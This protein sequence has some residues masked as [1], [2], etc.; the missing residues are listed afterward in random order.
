MY[1]RVS[2]A[3]RVGALG[4]PCPS[5]LEAMT[6]RGLGRLPPRAFRSFS[7][8]I[9]KFENSLL[10]DR[11][12]EVQLLMQSGEPASAK[13]A[14]LREIIANRTS[15]SAEALRLFS[16]CDQKYRLHT[17]SLAPALTMALQTH[18]DVP[19]APDV[20]YAMSCMYNWNDVHLDLLK[21]FAEKFAA[22]KRKHAWSAPIGHA[23]YGL[24][25]MQR[26]EPEVLLLLRQMA[27]VISAT[28]GTFETKML[29]KALFG[30]KG[31][32]DNSEE[33]RLLLRAF[34]P[35]LESCRDIMDERDISLAFTGLR[36]M[37]GK[38][39]ETREIIKILSESM[40]N[41]E[42]TMSAK[43]LGSILLSL[44]RQSGEYVETQMLL[45]VLA[46]KV[47][48][49]EDTFTENDLSNALNGMQ[50]MSSDDSKV[51][52]F[53]TVMKKKVF[54]C[55]QTFTA[56]NAGRA[57][58]G[59][60]N[61]KH[62][63]DMEL[64]ILEN[65]DQVMS[66][67]D[68]SL[69]VYGC[70]RRLWLE[71]HEITLLR[72]LRKK[73]EGCQDLLNGQSVALILYG[74]QQLTGEHEEHRLML[75]ALC[76]KRWSTQFHPGDIAMCSYGLVRMSSRHTEVQQILRRLNE[77]LTECRVQL[78]PN[79]IGG[80]LSGLQNFNAETRAVREMLRNIA[81]RIRTC[82]GVFTAK[83][84]GQCFRGLSHMTNDHKEVQLVLDALID[85]IEQDKQFVS[86][87]YT[88]TETLL[89][90]PEYTAPPN[91]SR[92]VSKLCKDLKRCHGS[93]ALSQHDCY[94]LGQALR[95]CTGLEKPLFRSLPEGVQEQ[96]L[97]SLRLCEEHLA[98]VDMESWATIKR[99]EDLCAN[100]VK[101]SVERFESDVWDIEMT[102]NVFLH[103][104]EAD[105]LLTLSRKKPAKTSRG[106]MKEKSKDVS[107][108]V[109]INIEI[110]GLIH[111]RDMKQRFHAM[112]DEYLSKLHGVVIL[113][114][115]TDIVTLIPQPDL[116]KEEANKLVNMI[117]GAITD[118][119]DQKR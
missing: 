73:L 115:Q 5:Y 15:S 38:A 13:L 7:A 4:L 99:K 18:D 30:L 37:S 17:E 101:K 66:A 74:L 1:A 59:F 41:P 105:I 107:N 12:R 8:S 112:R 49:C 102:R 48:A 81:E 82:K 46:A 106:K 103:G 84:V 86:T 93:G 34:I 110:D 77:T 20:C 16:H 39:S 11:R 26:E 3:R 68:I 36:A 61:M 90:L 9:A 94:M 100:L 88:F 108:T 42:V 78:Y 98:P 57:L 69:S 85:S 51:K 92:F 114:L 25:S 118:I 119:G 6:R 22:M 75:S 27:E 14:Q 21:E 52:A 31:F 95:L 10:E 54:A 24:K 113:G 96:L 80:L 45:D 19:S 89:G 109:L 116:Y 87:P 65:C 79:I 56:A 44:G 63:T 76:G 55:T 29:I 62:R 117:H 72:L 35:R 32:T 47:S 43:T 40:S 67:K 33:I 64:H 50:S 58:Y 2:F 70:Q 60:R 23:I 71:E 97:G 28:K 91:I 111:R 53:M 104:F 83:D